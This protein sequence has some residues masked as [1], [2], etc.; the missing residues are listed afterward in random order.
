MSLGK[1]RLV[2]DSLLENALSGSVV[3]NRKRSRVVVFEQEKSLI[4]K[5]HV[6]SL[7]REENVV[8]G[9]FTREYNDM[10]NEHNEKRDARVV[11][12][13]L[14]KDISESKKLLFDQTVEQQTMK[15]IVSRIL[16][17]SAAGVEAVRD[18]DA[19]GEE[20]SSRP[21]KETLI[22]FTKRDKLVT[23]TLAIFE[24][25]QELDKQDLE[26]ER[27]VLS[28][29]HQLRVSWSKHGSNG[30][31][32]SKRAAVPKEDEAKLRVHNEWL[33]HVLTTAALEGKVDLS[34][35]KDIM[36]LIM[37]EL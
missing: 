18:A 16:R 8:S 31:G 11:E 20:G 29:Q 22:P 21:D 37:S 28:K 12:E 30:G 13:Q 35:R 5:L 9:I 2:A 33:K 4:R 26:L 25:L 27:E 32:V 17:T 3:I 14:V 19:R 15:L 23:D 7:R 36:G 24:K 10:L 1:L 34:V 6:D